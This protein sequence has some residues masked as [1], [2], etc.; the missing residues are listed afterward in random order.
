MKS[1]DHSTKGVIPEPISSTAFIIA[2]ISFVPLLGVPFG[3]AAVLW[4]LLRLDRGGGKVAAVGAGGV[5][6]SLLLYGGLFYFGFVKR[7]GLYDHLREQLASTMLTNLVSEI[8]FYRVEHGHYPDSLE[9][10][11]GGADDP[12]A[13]IYDP[14]VASVK[15]KQRLFYYKLSEDGSGYYLRG[16]GPD[17]VPFT[18]DDLLPQV[19]HMPGSGIGL[20]LGRPGDSVSASHHGGAEAPTKRR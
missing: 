12:A 14:T 8:E 4:G 11:S 2:G 6:F 15:G 7:G 13:S 20:R 18:A 16:V 3:I 17:G 19:A 10:L 1:G 9:D 5:L